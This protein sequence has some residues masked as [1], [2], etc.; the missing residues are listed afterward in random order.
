[1]PTKLFRVLTAFAGII[2][3]AALG[4]Y[5]SV[6]FPLPPATASLAQVTEFGVQYHNVIFL[7]TWLQ[8][9]G[10]LLTVVFF[11][12][13]VYLANAM[14]R[15]AGLMTMLASAITLAVALAEGTFAIGAVQAGMNGQAQVALTCLDLTYVFVHIF[16]MLP[17]PLLFLALGAVLLSSDM[18]PRVFSL[19]SIALGVAFAIVGFVAFFSATAITVGIFLQIGQE[20]WVLVAAITLIVRTRKLSDATSMQEP[21]QVL[22]HRQ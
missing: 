7:D 16:L 11:L 22:A 6:P 1:M 20:L 17:A 13:L 3:V 18:L 12:A 8:A 2:G 15:F 9:V 10:S 21:G 19:L 5:Y 14:N 4:Y